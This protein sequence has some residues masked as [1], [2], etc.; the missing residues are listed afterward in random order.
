MIINDLSVT[1]ISY[2]FV[3]AMIT[4]NIDINNIIM[5]TVSI[6]ICMK[7]LTYLMFFVTYNTVINDY[8]MLIRYV[9]IDT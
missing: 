5:V 2:N 7:I 8:Q 6:I 3:I 9:R 1:D 4:V